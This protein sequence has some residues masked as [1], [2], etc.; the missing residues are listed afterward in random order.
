MYDYAVI[1]AGIAGASVAFELAQV[2]TVALI[3]AESR[4]GYH[5]TGRSAALYTPNYGN[6]VVRAINAGSGPFLLNPPSGFADHPLLTPRGLLTIAGPGQEAR[7]DAIVESAAGEAPVHHLSAKKALALVPLLRP[8]VV[9]AAAYEPGVMDI[10]VDALHQA[11]L[12]GFKA[13]DG[14]LLCNARVRRIARGAGQWGIEVAGSTIQAAIVI[15]AAGA[16][17]DQIGAMAGAQPLGLV[18]KRRSAIVADA[19]VVIDINSLPA[20]DMAGSEAYFKPEAGRI[21]ASFGDET[22]TEPQDA[23][24]EEL[25]I[26]LAADWLQRHTIIDLRRIAHSWAGLRTFVSDDA[27]VVGFDDALDD[28]FWLAA[29]GGYGIM[30][31]PALAQASR[32]LIQHN[33]LPDDF[34]RRGVSQGGISPARLSDVRPRSVIEPSSD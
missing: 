32:S 21:M 20:V 11:Y 23:Q 26:A 14:H 4:A 12:R 1:G 22:P 3:E 10:D 34:E 27:P 16:W 7:L 24:P 19:P 15:N 8:E 13:L 30:M 9:A 33:R 25:D 31:G 5:S 18:P 28:F 6:A 29:Q 17:A 2:G